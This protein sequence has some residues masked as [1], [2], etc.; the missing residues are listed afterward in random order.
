MSCNKKKNISFIYCT[1]FIDCN[2]N[3][4]QIIN[5]EKAMDLFI[6]IHNDSFD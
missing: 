2:Y 5:L 3:L 4:K 1:Y 6:N